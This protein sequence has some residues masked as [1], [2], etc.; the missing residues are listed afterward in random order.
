M[1][2]R[3]EIIDALVDDEPVEAAALKAALTDPAGRDYLVDAWTLRGLVQ[4]EMAIEAAPA[5]SASGP[6]RRVWLVAAALAGVCL[7]GGYLT[8]ARFPI[9][10]PSQ[11][12]VTAPPA[13][14]VAPA[15][16]AYP[17]P[18]ATRVIRLELDPN[19]KETSG[20]R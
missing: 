16:R 20:G 5:A 19:W 10:S 9:V 11:P 2:G 1:N 3:F 15:S 12:V 18:P 6:S 8:G 14:T 17:L 7:V 4:E 13:P